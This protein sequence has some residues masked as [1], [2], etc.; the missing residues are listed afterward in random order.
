MR[1][2]IK[3]HVYFIDEGNCDIFD[4][5]VEAFDWA[6]AMENARVKYIKAGMPEQDI[7]TVRI[8][9]IED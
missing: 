5:P 3:F 2:T 9:V 6:D 1:D 4:T 8:E 7:R